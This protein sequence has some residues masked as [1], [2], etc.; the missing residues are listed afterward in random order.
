[1][2]RDLRYKRPALGG[3]R[4]GGRITGI[5]G[6]IQAPGAIGQYAPPGVGGWG[7][8]GLGGMYESNPEWFG[9]D[10]WNWGS[11]EDVEWSSN[12]WQSYL[13]SMAQGFDMQSL[14]PWLD[15]GQQEAGWNWYNEYGPGSGGNVGPF[16]GVQYG[17]G[18][19]GGWQGVGTPTS[20]STMGTSVGG[21]NI[22]GS[23]DLGTGSAFAGGSM[24][25]TQTGGG[26][27]DYDCDLLGP[28]YNS[29]GECIACCD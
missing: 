19:V 8:W 7:D 11:M 13:D 14:F 27:W 29:Q 26:L 23:G 22:G 3:G 18:A 4:D 21:G 9:T 1:M 6:D 24:Y 28:S 25:G 2:A 10:E 12:M 15:W 17:G 16:T 5:P 20:G